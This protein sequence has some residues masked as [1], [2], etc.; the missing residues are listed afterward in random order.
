MPRKKTANA[1]AAPAPAKI[2]AD[3]WNSKTFAQALNDVLAGKYRRLEQFYTD[4][5]GRTFECVIYKCSD[6]IF[7]V[8]LKNPKKAVTSVAL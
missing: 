8:T 5:S 1:S 7:G 3:E 4:A 6:N 2:E